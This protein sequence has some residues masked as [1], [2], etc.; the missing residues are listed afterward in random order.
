MWNFSTL[1]ELLSWVATYPLWFAAAMT[2]PLVVLAFVRKVFPRPQMYF[3]LLLPL[4]LATVHLL[5]PYFSHTILILDA[6]FLL[7]VMVDA[8]TVPSARG[9]SVKRS[10]VRVAS[11]AKSHPVNTEVEYR[12]NWPATIVVT[13][14]FPDSFHLEP[15]EQT[16]YFSGRSRATFHWEAQPQKRGEYVLENVYVAAKSLLG[17]WV[18]HYRFPCPG[19]VQVYPDLKQ[20]TQYA[21]LAKTNR[22]SLL[23]IRKSRRAGQENDFERLRDY[24]RDDQ[25]KFMDWRATARRNK[26]T[27]RDFQVTQS[28]RLVFLLDCGRLMTNQSQGLTM[29][30]HALNSMLMLSYVAL[31]RGD[32][33]GLLCF[34][35]KIDCY[36]PPRGDSG[37]INRMLHAS[38]NIFPRMVESRYDEAF[39]FMKTRNPRRSLVILMTH[40][41][42]EVNANQVTKY[43]SNIHGKHLPLAVCMRDHHLF[44]PLPDH[45]HE[46]PEDLFVAA[47]AADMLTWRSQVLTGLLHRGALVLDAFPEH[48][49]APLVNQYLEI[50]ARQML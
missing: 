28:Q 12:G 50:K 43:I 11:L 7:V 37:Q 4:A 27:V 9:F 44:A 26:L 42:D 3:W 45:P 6:L 40:L 49:T 38:Y 17:F 25:F 15:S 21:I 46:E 19:V 30:D 20:L 39:Q 31:S 24:T 14:D 48:V 35:D 2:L 10:M 33:V 5:V 22:L 16:H 41:I 32:S 29:L 8:L 13:E 1:D 36:V 18:G 23:G 47:A 34:S